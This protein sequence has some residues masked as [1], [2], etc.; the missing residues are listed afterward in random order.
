MDYVNY[1]SFL[2]ITQNWQKSLKS[3]EIL[4]SLYEQNEVSHSD[5]VSYYLVPWDFVTPSEDKVRMAIDYG[6][7]IREI[8]ERMDIR[9]ETDLYDSTVIWEKRKIY[10]RSNY[11][12]D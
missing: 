7:K 10:R 6:Y 3:K 2:D 8:L 1:P 12:R 9:Y 4:L 5:I 11:E